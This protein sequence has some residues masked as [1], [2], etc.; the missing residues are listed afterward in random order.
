MRSNWYRVIYGLCN[1]IVVRK[2]VVIMNGEEEREQFR[3]EIFMKILELVEMQQKSNDRE[4]KI[5]SINMFG[6]MPS[7]FLS[8]KEEKQPDS[9]KRE[10]YNNLHK[11]FDFEKAENPDDS[12]P[13]AFNN[14]MEEVLFKEANDIDEVEIEERPFSVILTKYA[15]K[16]CSMGQF[17]EAAEYYLKLLYWNPADC[18]IRLSF[19][20]LFWKKRALEEFCYYLNETCQYAYRPDHF[21]KIREFYDLFSAEIGISDVEAAAFR[22]KH[23]V[24]PVTTARIFVKHAQEYEENGDF[25]KALTL[26]FSAYRLLKANDI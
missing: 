5:T 3:D 23:M 4:I 13:Y 9:E 12:H 2:E 10:S 26:Y 25:S 24:S 11:I 20:S 21:R 8:E 18:S 17:M 6:V 19:I 16:L 1:A 22:D 14:V 15:N 7:D